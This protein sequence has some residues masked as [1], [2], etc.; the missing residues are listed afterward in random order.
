MN[1]PPP[2]ASPA[3]LTRNDAAW[4]GLFLILVATVWWRAHTFAPTLVNRFDFPRLWPVVEGRAEPLDCDE[5]AYAYMG[6]RI[7]QGAVLYRDLAENKPPLGYWIYALGVRLGDADEWTIRWLP[8]PFVLATIV[9]I[10]W[11]AR[12][13]AGPLAAVIAA[14]LYALLATDPYVYG[15]GAQLEQPINFASISAL[16][17]LVA[18]Q[19]RPL[20]LWPLLAGVLTAAAT[21]IRPTSLVL[22]PVLAFLLWRAASPAPIR[23]GALLALVVGFTATIAACLAVLASQD[24]IPAAWENTVTAARALVAD[25]PAPPNAP[26]WYVRWLTGNSDPRDGRLPWPFGQTDWLV[27]WGRGAWPLWFFGT[28]SLIAFAFRAPRTDPRRAIALWTLAAWVQLIL[29]GQYW[30]HYYLLPTPG[31]ALAASIAVADALRLIRARETRPRAALVLIAVTLA[32]G[33]TVTIQVRDYLLVPATDL[34][35]R[36]K[37]GRQW[38][39]LRRLGE[40]LARQSALAEFHGLHVWGWQSPLYLYSGLDSPSRHF[41]VNQLVKTHIDRPHP[42]VDRWK[43]ELMADLE[44]TPPALVF[45]GDPPFEPLHRWLIQNYRSTKSVPTSPRGEGLWARR[46]LADPQR[47]PPAEGQAN[48]TSPRPVNPRLQP[49]SPVRPDKIR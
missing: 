5:A 42:L 34:T 41:F 11:L 45:C 38:V 37:G 27:W 3:F 7:N 19:R 12:A 15:N 22:L 13:I 4:I 2:D 10:G 36:Y 43:A 24:A 44:R 40:Y 39:T 20:L 49:A 21:L 6:R 17:A 47:F 9:V 31:I 30:A 25:T 48:L 46:D 32:I 18:W 28:S 35:I 29:P 23:R 8:V 33:G 26:P 16:A 1:P 14:F